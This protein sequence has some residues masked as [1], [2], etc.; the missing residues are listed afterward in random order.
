MTQAEHIYNAFG[1]VDKLKV[2]LEKAG[3]PYH[4]STLYRWN[5]PKPNGN[6]GRVP[7]N[8]YYA[9]LAAARLTGV[10]LP[11]EAHHGFENA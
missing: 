8:G 6:G 5:M 2:A 4:L 7:L 10:T 9:V 1:G 11:P 3:R